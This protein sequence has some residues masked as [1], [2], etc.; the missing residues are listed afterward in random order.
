[1]TNRPYTDSSSVLDDP[2]ELRRRMQRDA[3]LYLPG[4]LPRELVELIRAEMLVICR[5]AGWLESRND[6][7]EGTANR[8]AFTVEPEA[9]YMAVFNRQFALESLHRA[10]HHRAIVSVIEALEEEPVF[11]HPRAILRNIFPQFDAHTTPAHQ[12]FIHFQG[13]ER[14]YAAWIPFGDCSAEMGGLAVAE[15]SHREGL[16]DVQ[17]SLGAGALEVTKSFDGA[18]RWNPMRIGDV[19]V[20][21]CLSV[22]RGVHNRSNALRLSVD[23]RYQPV[24]TPVCEDAFHPHRRFVDW[25]DIYRE[26]RDES[27]QYYWKSLPL[28]VVPF[29]FRL[30]EQRDRVAFDMAANG[31]QR[32]VATLNRIVTSDPDTDKVRRARQALAALAGHAKG[33]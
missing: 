4:L 32:A 33:P 11:P 29:D 3:Y 25:P 12:D 8:T 16:Y 23:A 13:T 24:S 20:H 30:Y 28:D 18:W 5:D 27:L 15:G 9:A 21:H 1:M 7:R 17:P 19:L 26:W 10:I 22:H 6:P 14:C 2:E 31:D